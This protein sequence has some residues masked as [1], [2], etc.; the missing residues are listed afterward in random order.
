MAEAKDAK[1]AR[2]TLHATPGG[3]PAFE[4]AA[5]FCY[6]VHVDITVANVAML[7]C[8][9]R[10]LQMTDD[11]S[12]KSLELRAE[13]FLRDTVLPSIASSVAVL[14]TCEA[15]LP[16][17]EDVNLVARLIAAIANNVCKEQLASGLFSRLDQS[18]QLKP[19]AGIVE[20]DSPG[21]WWGK[22][23]AG[24]GLDFFQRLLSAVKSKG[25]RQETVTRILINYAQNS[26]YGLMACRDMQAA[27]KCGGVTDTDAVKKQR[28]VV[29]TIVGLLPAQSKKSPVPMAFL[30]GLLKTAM[31]LS[32]SNICKTDLEKR[33]GMQL[34][35]AILEDILIATGSGEASTAGTAAAAQHHTLYDTDVVAR[36]FSVF[37]NLDEDNE[38]DGGGC[39]GFDYDSPR[40]PKQSS[41][42]KASKLLDS[43]LAEIA[44][45]SNLVPPK[46]IS[47]AEILPD[48]ARL[49]TDGIYRAV[50]I[51]LKARKQC[52]SRPFL[53][54]SF[55]QLLLMLP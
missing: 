13:T 48:H 19:A 23:V 14:R 12:D 41:I 46:F 27:D 11:F 30:S 52:I 24:L 47:L 22:S 55:I 51:F 6:G 10:Y 18:A 40:S 37:L 50:D 38:E 36:I 45:D 21:D 39:G 8:A 25:L 17:A 53:F 43:Y 26:L 15:L 31:A 34:D 20:L 9:A 29:E 7:R 49:V 44:L 2:L 4:L 28:T 5:K 16:A 54:L 33:I 3:A 42:V 32:A 1:L 35:Q